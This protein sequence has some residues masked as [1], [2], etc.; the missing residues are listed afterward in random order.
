MLARRAVEDFLRE[1]TE[2]AR[3]ASRLMNHE[4]ERTVIDDAS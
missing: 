4:H 2:A 1:E 3:S